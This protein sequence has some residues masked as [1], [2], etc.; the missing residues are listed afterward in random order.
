MSEIVHAVTSTAELVEAVQ[1][2]GSVTIEVRGTL[3]NV[4]SLKLNPGQKLV[5]TSGASVYFESGQDGLVLTTDNIVENLE[6]HTNPERCALCNDTTGEGFGLLKLRHLRTTGC[7]RLIAEGDV[8]GGHVEVR[9][10]HILAA[11]ARPFEKRASGFGVEVIS[12]A[13][14]LWNRQASKERRVSAELRG[15]AVGRAGSP[16]HGTGILVGG[17]LGGGSVVVNLLETGEVYSDGGIAPGTP[18]K[19]S[20]GV[21]VVQGAEVDEVRNLGAVT[22]FGPNDMV[23]DN[24]GRVERWYAHANITSYGPSGI[25]FV[26]LGELGELTIDGLLETHGLGSCG[27]NSGEVKQT[28]SDTPSKPE[29]P[30]VSVGTVYAGT[31]RQA[32][33]ERVVTRG[34][35][36]IG[37]QVS[38]PIGSILIRKG[39]E[40]YGGVGASL[41]RGVVTKLA[42]VAF[43]LKPGGSA[44]ELIIGGGLTT[45]GKGIEA[46]ELHGQIDVLRISGAVGPVGGGFAVV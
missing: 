23:L 30:E 21:F 6:L 17:T 13:F 1:A 36:A 4:P 37:I 3:E 33:F 41:A 29:T 31:V 25:G 12:G 27:F 15:I 35:G 16:V 2:I 14:T 40:T 5:G 19:I 10:L 8:T 26:N 45:H 34:D 22:T 9:D 39:I 32:T 7:V 44:R 24:W 11:D 28:S 42:A 46:I 43:S 38:V 18:D 20:G